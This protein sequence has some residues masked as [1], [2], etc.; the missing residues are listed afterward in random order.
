MH[1]MVWKPRIAAE[2]LDNERQIVLE[3]I[4]MYEDD[5]QDKV[6]DVL[7]E[8]VFGEHPLG[9]A[10]I[11]RAR[12]RG[13]QPR[14]RAGG[15]PRAALRPAQRRAGR[16]RLGRPRRA[17]RARHRGRRRGRCRPATAP[18]APPPPDGQAARCGSSARTPSSTTCASAR[19]GIA[20]DDDRRW[21]LRVLD[22]VLGGTSSSRLF[23][24]VRERRGLAYSVYSFSA[25]H[26]GDRAGR[27]LRRHA[28]DNVG[29]AHARRGRRA[30]ALRR[31]PGHRRGARA[32]EGERQGPHGARR[33]SRPPRG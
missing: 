5:P 17:R 7:G 25:L 29:A 10:V 13:G 8:A 18:L 24:E 26:A 27:P 12:R 2:D 15:L 3:E 23:Q 33:W 14:G 20:R 11:G 21:A 6:F 4:A 19:P 30:R 9:R 1:E 16:G 31:R 22:N 28:A 32:L